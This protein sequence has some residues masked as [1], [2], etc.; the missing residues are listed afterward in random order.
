MAKLRLDYGT[1]FRDAILA[2]QYAASAKAA[3]IFSKTRM[4]KNDKV[5]RAIL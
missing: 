1:V 4:G 5:R 2:W 3:S